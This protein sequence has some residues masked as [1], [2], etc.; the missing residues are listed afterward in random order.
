VSPGDTI[1]D[2]MA[3]HNTSDKNININVY[4]QDFIYKEPF[5]GKKDFLQRGTSEYSMSEWISFSPTEFILLPQSKRH[6]NYVI[7][8]PENAK[9]GYYGVLFFEQTTEDV[10]A[11]KSVKIITRLGSLFFLETTRKDKSSEITNI[12]INK[13]KLSGDIKNNGN[14]FIFPKGIYYILDSNG[15]VNT[16][17]EIKKI[18]LPCDKKANFDI[19]IPFEMQPGIYTIV[20]TFDLN[21]GDSLVREIDFEKNSDVDIKLLDIRD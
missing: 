1:S 9:G 7:K 10:E 4:W 12:S 19:D 5:Y 20:I 6:I 11:Q 15:I 16:R 13:G 14:V 21:S 18:Y 3:I 17:G 2:T 8:V